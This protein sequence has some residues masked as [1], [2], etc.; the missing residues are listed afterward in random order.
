VA[1][2]AYFEAVSKGAD[3]LNFILYVP[4]GF[5]SLAKVKIPNV[6]ETQDPSII[7]TA[8]FNHGQEIW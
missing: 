4:V 7:F 5:G 3:L 6:E 1:I 8:Q 2:N